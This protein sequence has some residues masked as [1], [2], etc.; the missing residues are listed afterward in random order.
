MSSESEGFLGLENDPSDNPIPQVA[1][2][3][4][5]WLVSL[6]V[7]IFAIVIGIIIALSDKGGGNDWFRGIRFGIYSILIGCIL[8]VISSAFSYTLK[9]K[10]APLSLILALPSFAIVVYWLFILAIAP[11]ERA[12]LEKADAEYRKKE[13]EKIAHI[14]HWGKEFKTHPEL[15]T[16]DDFWSKHSPTNEIIRY[17]L[18]NLLRDDIS[19]STNPAIKAYVLQK[20]PQFAGSI[21]QHMPTSELENYANDINSPY[22]ETALEKLLRTQS[23]DFNDHYRQLVL[24]KHR[25]LIEYLFNFGC[26]EKEELEQMVNDPKTQMIDKALAERALKQNSFKRKKP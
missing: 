19:I 24:T 20:L 13:N 6:L 12:K 4:K 9:E 15:I 22:A 11:H 2:K 10:L 18:G 17:G 26:F 23:F 7:P 21:L 3:T 25:R 14:Q 5:W 16:S 1:E 8:S